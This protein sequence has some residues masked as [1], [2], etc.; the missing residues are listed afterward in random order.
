[1]QNKPAMYKKSPLGNSQKP[2]NPSLYKRNPNFEIKFTRD[3]IKLTLNPPTNEYGLH[4][5]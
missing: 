2:I 4:K 1:M 3:K 5:L